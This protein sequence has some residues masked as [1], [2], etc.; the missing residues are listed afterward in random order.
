MATSQ[1]STAP[2]IGQ[3]ASAILGMRQPTPARSPGGAAEELEAAPGPLAHLT[4]EQ[5]VAQLSVAAERPGALL[6]L[7]VLCGDGGRAAHSRRRARLVRAGV[8]PPLVELV[9]DGSEQLEA[10]SVLQASHGR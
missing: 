9:A 3:I 6:Q 2:A 4:A 8:L 1:A 7:A 10:L 5:L